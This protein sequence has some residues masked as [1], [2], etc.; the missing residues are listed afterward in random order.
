MN[1]YGRLNFVINTRNN[2][3]VQL[4]HLRMRSAFSY[5]NLYC[6]NYRVQV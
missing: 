6:V 3:G 4:S 5:R 2:D 1:K